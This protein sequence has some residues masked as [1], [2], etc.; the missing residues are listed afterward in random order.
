MKYVFLSLFSICFLGCSPE[1][2]ETPQPASETIGFNEGWWFR[3]ELNP[4][5]SFVT[6]DD[7][8]V[9]NPFDSDPVDLPHDWSIES[10][11]DSTLASAT[12][13]LPGG[14]GWY[15]KDFEWNPESGEH[16]S[17]Y[18]EAISSNSEVWLNGHHLGERPN[19]Y[20]SFEYDLTPYLT[21]GINK[22]AV[23][24]DRSKYADSRWYTGAG[25]YGNVYLNKRENVYIPTWGITLTTP[26]VDPAGAV[27]K[28]NTAVNNEADVNQTVHI[29]YSVLDPDGQ[30]KSNTEIS[31]ELVKSGTGE[32]SAELE[33]PD[34]LLWSPASP[35]LYTALVEIS[36]GNQLMERQEIPF[37]I[38][39]F[40]FDPEEGFFLNG[41]NMLIKGVCL[42][43][44][45][46]V[47]GA[48]VPREVWKRRLAILKEAGTNALRISH[49]P[50]PPHL[51]DLA[52]SMGFLVMAE[53]FDEWTGP[54]NKWIEGWNAGRP[55]QDGY[56]EY[57]EEWAQ[58]D[59]QDMVRRDRNHPSV[60]MWSIGNEIDYPNDP[61]SHAVL[62]DQPGWPDYDPERPDANELGDI[63]RQ[64]AGWI[65]E[66]DD[67]RPVTAALASGLMSNETTYPAALDVV[68]YNYQESRYAEDH[69]KFPDRV[70][71]GS[72]NR[73]ADYDAWKAVRDHSYISAQ[74]IWTGIDYLGEARA[75]PNRTSRSGLLDMAGFKKARFYL[76]QSFWDTADVVQVA[77]APDNRGP[78]NAELK[79]DYAGA[80]ENV[81]VYGI[82]NLDSIELF[83]NDRS[84]GIQSRAGFTDGAAKWSVPFEEGTVKV[85]GIKNGEVIGTSEIKTPGEP[86]S[87]R[88]RTGQ[89]D[90]E[91]IHAIVEIVDGEGILATAAGNN[92]HYELTGPARVIGME[93]GNPDSHEDYRSRQRNAWNGRLMI[94]LE[95]S[96]GEGEIEL[97]VKSDNVKQASAVW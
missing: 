20:I 22:L 8:E 26:E 35:R 92:I 43:H 80:A 30:L 44:D 94:Y 12:G 97:T 67:T 88:I 60:I 96:G 23:K 5:Y 72:E 7:L 21:E 95:T 29:A 93:S 81:S 50:A 34:P 3:V 56:H 79:W 25:I 77:T 31:A 42:H 83:I 71:L 73:R 61:F 36:Q 59:I 33:I 47:F 15:Q 27:L 51:L 76:Q 11:F 4:P 18:F 41:E 28:V 66:L 32:W 55:G 49:N 1:A 2:A 40:N 58:K 82:T 70:I 64:L 37:G 84:L 90:G 10:P 85:N 53:A 54:K 52:D 74:F 91:I 19:G 6:F 9:A 17:I 14:I 63:A 69:E 39:H 57:F 24:V 16:V 89:G 62:D 13:F 46:G 65:R 45:A 75:W 48:A 87:L 38:R 86:A 78:V 68:G